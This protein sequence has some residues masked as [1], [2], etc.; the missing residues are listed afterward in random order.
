MKNREWIASMSDEELAELLCK[1][2]SFC[3]DCPGVVEC[4]YPKDH[5]ASKEGPVYAGLV[6]WLGSEH[7]PQGGSHVWETRDDFPTNWEVFPPIE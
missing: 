1:S 5:E 2:I 3:S 4:Q 7:K 6:K